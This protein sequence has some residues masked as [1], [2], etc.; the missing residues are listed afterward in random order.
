ME[1]DAAMPFELIP[2]AAIIACLVYGL[3]LAGGFFR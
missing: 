3:A 1:D 2:T